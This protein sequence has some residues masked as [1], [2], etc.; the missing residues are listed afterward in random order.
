MRLLVN[1]NVTGTVIRE[2]RQRGHDVLVR[3]PDLNRKPFDDETKRSELRARFNK[4]PG[5]EIPAN[6]ISHY[7]SIPLSV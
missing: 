1:E 7:P 4:I 6:A 3:F 2:L 5:I